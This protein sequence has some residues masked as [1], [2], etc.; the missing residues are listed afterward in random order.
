MCPGVRFDSNGIGDPVGELMGL[1]PKR[2]GITGQ[3]VSADQVLVSLQH[4]GTA[5][6]PLFE[7]PFDADL[8]F[9]LRHYTWDAKE[10]TNEDGDLVHWD[11]LKALA[12]AVHEARRVNP[13]QAM[14]ASG[15]KRASAYA[16]RGHRSSLDELKSY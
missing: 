10:D 16:V 5:Q 3:G 8:D 2:Y 11:H 1:D 15:G 12:Y 6:P 9:D 4:A 13:G 7:L 14:I